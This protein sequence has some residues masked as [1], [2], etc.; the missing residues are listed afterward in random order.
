MAILEDRATTPCWYGRVVQAVAPVRRAAR[1]LNV[2]RERVQL[3][4]VAQR[5]PVRG[6]GADPGDL[7]GRGGDRSGDLGRVGVEA[8]GDPLQRLG[9]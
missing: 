1:G 2:G 7:I 9:V 6:L 4:S 8:P 5:R 3:R